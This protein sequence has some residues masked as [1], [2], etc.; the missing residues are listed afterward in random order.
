MS[1]EWRRGLEVEWE[2]KDDGSLGGIRRGEESCVR[3]EGRNEKEMSRFYLPKCLV[4]GFDGK[5]V[6]FNITEE[7]AEKDFMKPVPPGP[8]EYEIYK[9]RET[10]LEL[11]T[12][13]PRI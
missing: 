5:D 10:P 3:T 4:K 1:R 8:A 2:R 9:T 11:E 13:V 12:S 7:Q 6:R